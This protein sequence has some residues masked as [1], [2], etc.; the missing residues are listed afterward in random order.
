MVDPI[1][2]RRR[3]AA[4]ALMLATGPFRVQSATWPEDVA[5]RVAIAEL[6]ATSARRVDERTLMPFSE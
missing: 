4:M 5:V 1:D 2:L 3:A 6:W